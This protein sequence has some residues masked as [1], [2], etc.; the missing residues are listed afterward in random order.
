MATQTYT[1]GVTLSSA[2]EFNRFD[3]VSYAVLSGVAGTNTIT[4][5]GPANYTYAATTPPVWFIPANTNTGAT[6]INITPSGGAAL[7]AKNIFNGGAACIG[8]ELR[9]G[10]PVGIVYDGTQFN[11]IG[12]APARG[13]FTGSFIGCTTIPTGTV[14]YTKIGNVVTLDIPSFTGTSNS[15]SKSVTGMPA[16]LIPVSVKNGICF[17]SDN[18][19]SYV[20]SQSE[21][22]TDGTIGYT[23]SASGGVWTA[24][25]TATVQ[26]MSMTYTLT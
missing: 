14:N 24:S 18:G 4:A 6:T 13:T 5:T 7:G 16:A 23:T 8:G 20:A 22:A 26:R 25:G 11:I 9:A 15:G 21:I 3:T 19:G 1:D 10:V 12:L 2:A 17:T